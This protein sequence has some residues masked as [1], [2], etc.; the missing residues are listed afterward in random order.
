MSTQCCLEN[1]HK[2][3]NRKLKEILQNQTSEQLLAQDLK[4][5]AKTGF[6]SMWVLYENALSR[7]CFACHYHFFTSPSGTLHAL[8]LSSFLI[9][10]ICH[11]GLL[12]DRAGEKD[13]PMNRFI[14][15]VLYSI[16]S[17]CF[18]D[19]DDDLWCLVFENW[20]S[21]SSWALRCP[22]YHRWI[23][24][25][26]KVFLSPALMREKQEGGCGKFEFV[27]I[28]FENNRKTLKWEKK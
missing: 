12:R 9:S 18:P 6:I 1:R 15:L 7:H 25:G 3:T 24:A 13:S 4:L 5:T 26:I 23:S 2:K 21:H 11:L 10:L 28:A 19:C 16:I 27:T 20:P 14:F 17:V 22:S 8:H